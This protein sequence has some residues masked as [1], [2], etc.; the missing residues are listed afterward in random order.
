MRGQRDLDPVIDVE[1]F[2]MVVVRLSQQRDAVH[3]PP[4]LAEIGKR[5]LAL[6]R[7][8][9][10]RQ[11]P[12]RMRG[13]QRAALGIGKFGN[14]HGASPCEAWSFRLTLNIMQADRKSTR[15]NSSH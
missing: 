1:P 6:D 12:L 8:T 5:E 14:G 9:L 3:E 2:G 13:E 10:A 11:R 15:L 7:P 4:R